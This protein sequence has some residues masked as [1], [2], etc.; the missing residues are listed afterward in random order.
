MALF[1]SCIRKTAIV[2]ATLA[3]VCTQIETRTYSITCFSADNHTEFVQ[4]TLDTGILFGRGSCRKCVSDPLQ[5]HREYRPDFLL[6]LNNID[7]RLTS[8]INE[9]MPVR[10]QLRV[11]YCQF[12]I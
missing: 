9:A 8:R 12:N 3:I 7:Y 6:G 10:I 4:P 1:S 11:R 2:L 5:Q